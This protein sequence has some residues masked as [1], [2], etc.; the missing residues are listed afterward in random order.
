MWLGGNGA[1]DSMVLKFTR[2]GKFVMQIG[3]AVRTSE[4]RSEP[5]G[6]VAALTLDSAANEIYVADGYG[7]HRVIV[8]DADT[9][10]IKRQWGAYGK[11]PTDDKLPPYDPRPRRSSPI[12]CIASR[13][14]RTAT[15]MSATA[16]NNRVQVFRKDGSFV[17][18]FV[19]APDTRGP[20]SAW[21]LAFSPL[22]RKQNY[23]LLI[24][25]S[26]NVLETVRRRDGTVV[27]T[28]GRP[29]RNAGDFHW[30]HVGAFIRAAISTPAKSTA[31]NGCRN[32]SRRSEQAHHRSRRTVRR[33]GS[34]VGA[35]GPAPS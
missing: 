1:T 18:Q 34:R 30:V 11:P 19:F 35:T 31:E 4:Q 7:N 3:K 22:D 9:G 32:S 26:N 10:A 24:D 6:R 16:A 25:G 2:D 21:G 27:G 8:F 5:V 23:F 33:R 14:P 28:T 20:G 17:R 15:S 12:R 13:S 29:G